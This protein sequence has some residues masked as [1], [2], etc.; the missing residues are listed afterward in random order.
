[1]G[2]PFSEISFRKE[3]RRL[4]FHYPPQDD[5]SFWSKNNHPAYV[6]HRAE[7]ELEVFVK[8]FSLP[9]PGLQPEILPGL[10]FLLQ[11]RGK[12]MDF[13]PL[14]FD[15]QVRDGRPAEYFLFLQL[16][17]DRYPLDK[18]ILNTRKQLR[19]LYTHLAQALSAVHRQGFW[20]TD[21][22]EG[23]ILLSSGSF[24][25]VDLDALH[26]VDEAFDYLGNPHTN[27][28]LILP[29]IDFI[30]FE[31]DPGLLRGDELNLLQL[32]MLMTVHVFRRTYTDPHLHLSRV[33]REED[34][35]K[36]LRSSSLLAAF[37]DGFL[38]QKSTTAGN[39]S[40][41]WLAKEIH[42]LITKLIS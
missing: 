39:V 23:N 3:G 17:D 36:H 12:R 37:R 20:H 2:K 32:L 27:K 8:Y 28:D 11:N 4:A 7:K 6:A 22:K 34:F 1:V 42:R 30:G 9:E 14:I 18:I 24:Y 10:P 13:L 29:L 25:L 41:P 21:L 31:E 40:Y 38:R 5:K 15:F 35:R 16:L 26:P 19:V 33:V